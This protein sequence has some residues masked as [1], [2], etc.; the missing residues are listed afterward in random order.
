MIGHVCNPRRARADRRVAA[1]A[2]GTPTTYLLAPHGAP[3]TTEDERDWPTG[4]IIATVVLA[5]IAIGLGVW[6]I[7]LRGDLNDEKASNTALRGQVAQLRERLVTEEQQSAAAEQQ[8]KAIGERAQR[9]YRRVRASYVA[10]EKEAG[11]LQADIT[12]ENAQLQAARQ[13]TASATGEEEQVAAQLR[14]ARAQARV[15]AA[16]A[17]GALG[18]IDLFFD[19][20]NSDSGANRAIARLEELRQT[21]QSAVGE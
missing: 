1:V 17:R 15:T 18:A 5:L 7:I 10:E 14:Q 6:A 20:E 3:T 21:C 8:E 2:P 4:W 13:A 19:A 9:A 16:C 11:Q 12:R